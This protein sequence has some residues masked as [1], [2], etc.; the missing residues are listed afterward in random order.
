MKR[1]I[2]IFCIITGFI[3]TNGKTILFIG[4]SITDGNWGSPSTYPCS[5][6]QRNKTDLN[7]VLG[8][9]FVEMT[10]GYF[11]GEYPD[12]NYYFNPWQFLC[13]FV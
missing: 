13:G 3:F 6:D 2:F 12:S 11:M 9:G 1:F 7:H 8:H 4:D 10:A 5:S